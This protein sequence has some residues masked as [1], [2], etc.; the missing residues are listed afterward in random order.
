MT[1]GVHASTPGNVTSCQVLDTSGI[2]FLNRSLI[3]EN[4]TNATCFNITAAN[5]ELNCQ[6]NAIYNVSLI[7]TGVYSGQLNSTVRNCNLS[8]ATS[9]SAFGLRFVGLNNSLITNIT[10]RA[11]GQSGISM[12]SCFQNVITYI[13]VSSSGTGFSLGDSDDNVIANITLTSNTNGGFDISSGSSNNTFTNITAT[14]TNTGVNNYGFSLAGGSSNNTFSFINASSNNVGVGIFGSTTVNNTFLSS[15]FSL[16]DNIG[17]S[18]GAISNIFINSTFFSNT[19][20]LLLGSV[21]STTS[22]NVFSNILF[23]SNND[24]ISFADS[25][26]NNFSSIIINNSLKKP[27][28]FSRSISSPS[29]NFIFNL[30]ILNTNSS[31]YDINFDSVGIDNTEFVDSSFNGYN[32]TGAGGTIIFTKS[33]FGKIKFLASVNGSNSNITSVVALG[34]NSLFINTSVADFNKSANL[35]LYNAQSRIT[36]VI[37]RDGS[38]CPDSICTALTSLTS[39]NITFNVTG[40]G[41]Y[42]IVETETTS[43]TTNSSSSSGSG[44]G[45]SINQFIVSPQDLVAGYS[46][47]LYR[48]ERYR[49]TL[50]SSNHTVTLTTFNRTSA[51]V[52]VASTPQTLVLVLGVPQIID[53][54]VSSSSLIR[55]VLESVTSGTANIRIGLVA[56]ETEMLQRPAQPITTALAPESNSYF[57]Q[58]ILIVVLVALCTAYFLFIRRRR[59]C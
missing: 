46:H 40:G 26:Y 16:N 42:S 8:M 38:A 56:R 21:G 22:H 10:T 24:T 19:R 30:T 39:G 27:I 49:F 41:M 54:D 32:F 31:Y 45:G 17:L 15:V 33:L 59:K 9:G 7:G 47:N 29:N 14:L 20:G 52:I 5:V 58:I 51:T 50:G 4:V 57:M 18:I 48:G 23:Q 34:E 3:N 37:Y 12:T 25:T 55:L 2:Y 11:N 13:S 35:T 1:S 6:G 43:G 36:P 28:A 44:G 53:V